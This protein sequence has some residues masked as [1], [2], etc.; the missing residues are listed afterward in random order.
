[1]NDAIHVS[2]DECYDHSRPTVEDAKK[3]VDFYRNM[4]G[5]HAWGVSVD[6]ETVR[7]GR[8]D[9]FLPGQVA[10]IHFNMDQSMRSLETSAA[11]ELIHVA[12][13]RV[14]NVAQKVINELPSKSREAF[15]NL[16]CDE[17]EAFT[18]LVSE[19]LVALRRGDHLHNDPFCHYCNTARS[20]LEVR[21]EG[22]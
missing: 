21:A 14:E 16:L 5:L 11:H 1:M 19:A 7:F 9:Y 20:G 4:L 8:V 13:A 12:M 6:E 22:K 2:I 15:T 17:M 18:A 10:Q 3:F